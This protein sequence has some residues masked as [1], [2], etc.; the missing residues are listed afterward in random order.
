[1]S[2]HV[3]VSYFIDM[4]AFQIHNKPKMYIDRIYNNINQM[5]Q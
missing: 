4:V 5:Q 3:L 2:E 1:M